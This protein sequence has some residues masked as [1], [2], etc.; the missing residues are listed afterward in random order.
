MKSIELRDLKDN[1]KFKL[2]KNSKVWY[3]LQN[4]L[5]GA[6]KDYCYITATISKRTYPKYLG[7][8]VWV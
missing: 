4:K 8:M 3:R 2:S 7:T 1:A 5:S 6:D